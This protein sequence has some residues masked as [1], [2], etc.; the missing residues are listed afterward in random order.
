MNL[1]FQFLAKKHLANAFI[2]LYTEY[3]LSVY[4]FPGNQTHDLDVASFMLYCLSY[5]NANKI[6]ISKIGG[7]GGN[8]ISANE[9]ATSNTQVFFKK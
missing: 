8:R 3:T 4:A 7:K 9:S 6:N 2:Q 1:H 5:R